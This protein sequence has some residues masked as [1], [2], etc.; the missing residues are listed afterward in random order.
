MK[1][2][3]FMNY[4]YTICYNE[5]TDIHTHTHTYI[6]IYFKNMSLYILLYMKNMAIRIASYVFLYIGTQ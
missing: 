5:Y 6:Y 1:L 2:G 4:L 3:D